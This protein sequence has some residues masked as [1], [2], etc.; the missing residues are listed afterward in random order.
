V[1]IIPYPGSTS[2]HSTT[3]SPTPVPFSSPATCATSLHITSVPLHLSSLLVWPPRYPQSPLPIHDCP[4]GHLPSTIPCRAC[5]SLRQQPCRCQTSPQAS[6]LD[7][8]G[9]MQR[10][11]NSTGAVPTRAFSIPMKQLLR[12][13]HGG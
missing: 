5:Q 2:G 1:H 4:P 7:P 13:V 10:P 3:V 6:D 12:L 9:R 11:P 8:D